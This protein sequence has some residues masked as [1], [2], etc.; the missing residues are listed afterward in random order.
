M[1][2][3]AVLSFTVTH[4]TRLKDIRNLALT[5]KD[6]YNTVNTPHACKNIYKRVF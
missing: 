6:G 3:N 5:C 4:L 2:N 1:L